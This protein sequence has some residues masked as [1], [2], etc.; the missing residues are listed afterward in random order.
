MKTSCSIPYLP[1]WAAA[2][3][4]GSLSLFPLYGWVRFLPLGIALLIVSYCLIAWMGRT[5]QHR[6]RLARK[7]LTAILIIGIAVVG[8]TGSIIVY[9]GAQAPTDV[10]PYIIVLGAKV[11]PDGPSMSLQERVDAA[12][13]Y[14]SDNPDTVAVVSGGRGTDEPI[15]E[16]DCMFTQ[17]TQ[18]GIAPSRIWV[19]DQATS[20][21]ENLKFSLDI[22]EQQTGF[23]PTTMGVV[24]SEYHL[25]RTSLQAKD[26][27]LDLIGIPARTTTWDRWLHYV[28]REIAGVWHYIL[29]GHSYGI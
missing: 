4:I 10:C 19:E 6:A 11:R 25:F 22:I 12:Y 20:T 21:W 14:L 28:L 3:L 13:A 9:T 18:R 2:I 8:T 24:S 1:A 17:L 7:I 23:R 16:A 29:L 5:Q 26:W 15:S 27:G